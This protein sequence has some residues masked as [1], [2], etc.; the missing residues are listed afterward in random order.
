M[1]L[2]PSSFFQKDP[3]TRVERSVP[4]DERAQA[5]RELAGECLSVSAV[6]VVQ[7]VEP[8]LSKERKR[9]KERRE[10]GSNR[11]RLAELGPSR[12]EAVPMMHLFSPELKVQ[13]AIWS[14]TGLNRKMGAKESGFEGTKFQI[15]GL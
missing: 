14:L 11:G 3:S 12:M 9:R 7:S 10:K 8:C 13:L 5:R 1:I 2:F 15:V 4:F 6:T